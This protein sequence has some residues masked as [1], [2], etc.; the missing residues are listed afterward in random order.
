MK[1]LWKIYQGCLLSNCPPHHTFEVDV[2]EVLKLL[3][4]N[5]CYF[6]RWTS[7]FDC[8]YKT[9]WWYCV[10]DA[11]IDLVKLTA[12][13]R[14]RIKR[15]QKL[16]IINKVIVNTGTGQSINEDIDSLLDNLLEIQKD[17]FKTYPLKYRPQTDK[18]SF[19]EEMKCLYKDSD[20]W[21]SRDK[22]TN[23]INAYAI[24]RKE[25]D[26]AWLKVVKVSPKYINNDVNAIIVYEIVNHYLGE[27]HFKYICDGERNIRH[28]TNY[29]DF[30]VKNLNFRYAYCKLHILYGT[31]MKNAI[32]ILFPIRGIIYK[33]GEYNK[34]IYNV[35]CLLKQ[36][37][38][39][40]SF[41]SHK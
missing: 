37:E 40:L 38:Y 9:E 41:L 33:I 35:A 31:F 16:N 36:H 10:K 20:L 11:P 22:E 3:A 19:R 30:L 27:E 29:Q 8:G 15:G 2:N 13:Q 28:Q 17:S 12:K 14:Y 6:A 39:Y 24:I 1:N 18:T 25:L 4:H 26:F 23:E 32:K 7:D 34:T 21:I 5:N